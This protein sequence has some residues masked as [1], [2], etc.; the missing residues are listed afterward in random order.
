ML[1]AKIERECVFGQPAGFRVLIYFQHFL[2]CHE[3][4]TKMNQL[5]EGEYAVAKNDVDKL[6]Q[7]LGQPPLP[8]LQSTLDEKAAQ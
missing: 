7:E 5:T 6:R 8:S 3:L 2:R 1:E 4:R